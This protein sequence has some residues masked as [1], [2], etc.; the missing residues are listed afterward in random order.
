MQRPN[1]TY[2]L[3][4]SSV[5]KNDLVRLSAASIAIVGD[6]ESSSSSSRDA[7]VLSVN[8][9][10]RIQ[11]HLVVVFGPFRGAMLHGLHRNTLASLLLHLPSLHLTST[12][13]R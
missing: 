4:P 13:N 7:Q 1:G 10:G 8:S 11:H 2:V 9:D 5:N 12:M 6:G 3:R